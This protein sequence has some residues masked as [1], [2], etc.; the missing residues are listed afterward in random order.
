MFLPKLRN[1]ISVI[2]IVTIAMACLRI[3]NAS[4]HYLFN[5]QTC[6]DR[7]YCPHFKEDKMETQGKITSQVVLLAMPRYEHRLMELKTVIN[8]ASSPSQ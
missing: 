7:Y 1:R 3:N 6:L 8:D 5:S 2:V 4:T